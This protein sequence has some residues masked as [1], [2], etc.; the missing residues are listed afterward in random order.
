MINLQGETVPAPE[1]PKCNDDETLL[2]ADGVL[3]WNGYDNYRCKQTFYQANGYVEEYY[4]DD[5]K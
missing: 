2:A 3:K 4:G 5:S 1:A